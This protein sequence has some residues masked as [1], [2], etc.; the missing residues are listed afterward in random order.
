[1]EGRRARDPTRHGPDPVPGLALPA[2]VRRGATGLDGGDARRSLVRPADMTRAVFLDRDGVLTEPIVRAG[3]P[4]S[5]ATASDLVIVDGAADECDRLRSAG[6]RLVVVSN[7]PEVA[8]G[9]L[10]RADLETMHLRLGAEIAVDSIRC[11]PHDD[12]DGCACRK[13]K[14]G[15]LLAAAEDFAIDLPRSYMVGDRWRDVEAGR[16]A[17]C[18][19]VFIDRG[20]DERRPESPD[21]VVSDLVKACDWI[22]ADV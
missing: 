19:T 6:F 12:G 15:M 16:S 9:T 20:Y 2:D 13:P 21:A 1:M 17:G 4:Y 3:R 11:C 18:R 5:A 10:D 14:P 8:R 22:L 7:Q